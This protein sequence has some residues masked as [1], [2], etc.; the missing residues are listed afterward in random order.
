MLLLLWSFDLIDIVKNPKTRGVWM[1]C[2]TRGCVVMWLGSQ[3]ERDRARRRSQVSDGH[4]AS[5][6][7]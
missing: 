6:R 5:A 2:C 7:T 1:P 4:A 3:H